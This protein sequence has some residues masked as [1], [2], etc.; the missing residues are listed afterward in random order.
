MIHPHTQLRL[1]NDTVGYGVFATQFIPK[2]TI[3]YVK[4]SM[5]IEISPTQYLLYQP[6]MQEAI[7]KYS[8]IDER[9]YRSVYHLRFKS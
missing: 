2:G 7:E 1:I 4:D 8:Y 3:V 5:E 9:G 6:E